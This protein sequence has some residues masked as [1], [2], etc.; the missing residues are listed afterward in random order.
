MQ[1]DFV[2]WYQAYLSTSGTKCIFIIHDIILKEILHSKCHDSSPCHMP[3]YIPS[4]TE[5]TDPRSIQALDSI[6]YGVGEDR[7]FVELVLDRSSRQSRWVAQ[8]VCH[9]R[10]PCDSD[11][12]LLSLFCVYF[13]PT[14]ITLSSLVAMI[15]VCVWESIFMNLTA[16]IELDSKSLPSG[17]PTPHPFYTVAETLISCAACDFLSC[18]NDTCSFKLRYTVCSLIIH[19][20]Y[21]INTYHTA[22]TACTHY[23]LVVNV[24]PVTLSK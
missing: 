18:I 4:K 5:L 6:E 9:V 19:E 17:Q 11:R 1:L 16:I 20:M 14:F 21:M 15:V 10:F 13:C 7:F 8:S 2:N 22:T 24:W 23:I 3:N 12:L